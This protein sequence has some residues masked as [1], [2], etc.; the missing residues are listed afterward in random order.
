M[1]KLHL[2]TSM[3]LCILLLTGCG[4][5]NTVNTPEQNINTEK[6]EI[7]EKVEDT[8]LEKEVQNNTT[9]AIDPSKALETFNSHFP[10]VGL[11]KIALDY[12]R[13]Q[14]HYD[15]EGVDDNFEYEMEINSETGEIIKEE[16]ENLDR[17]DVFEEKANIFNLS[18]AIPVQDAITKV[19]ENHGGEFKEWTLE[20]DDGILIYE[21]DVIDGNRDFEVY[22]NAE[23]GEILG[24]DD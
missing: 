20:K 2:I 4:N 16:K 21:I 17:D 11:T 10:N 8:T 13:G 3:G 6:T 19:L 14:Y 7:A 9:A 12:Y 23:T 1:K 15:I 24:I 18:D 5:K 22:V